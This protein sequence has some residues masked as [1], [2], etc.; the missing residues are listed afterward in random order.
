MQRSISILLLVLAVALFSE[1]TATACP[2][3]PRFGPFY[4]IP[5]VDQPPPL[6][7]DVAREALIELIK[8]PSP[9]HLEG[10]PLEKYVD[11]PVKR[12]PQELIASWGPFTL[13]LA[14]MEY[15]FERT[16]GPIEKYCSGSYRGAFELHGTR[17]LALPPVATEFKSGDK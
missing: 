13:D 3:R 14:Q 1:L 4:S 15:R 8:S 16:S 2:R 9:G 12:Q 7:G 5:T 17:W 6:T 10:F 11:S